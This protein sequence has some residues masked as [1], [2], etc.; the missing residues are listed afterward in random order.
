MLKEFGATKYIPVFITGELYSF[1]GEMTT[2]CVQN[3]YGINEEIPAIMSISYTADY[4]GGL[5][6]TVAH[7]YVHTLTSSAELTKLNATPSIWVV[8]GEQVK[9]GE[10]AADCG[11]YVFTGGAQEAGAYMTTCTAEQTEISI[12][13]INN[14]Y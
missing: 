2:G 11:R 3:L 5:R 12:A 1:C 8:D 14:T 7:E 4:Y 9:P 6:D 13:I 10:A